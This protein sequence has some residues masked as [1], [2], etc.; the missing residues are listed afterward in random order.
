MWLQAHQ[1]SPFPAWPGQPQ[2][3]QLLHDIHP[4][5]PRSN[6]KTWPLAGTFRGVCRKA[7]YRSQPCR[8]DTPSSNR[9][10]PA[11][12]EFSSSRH[13]CFEPALDI[14][15]HRAD[16]VFPVIDPGDRQDPSH[17]ITDKH[18]VCLGQHVQHQAALFTALPESTQ[19]GARMTP[20]IPQRSS[21]G[22]SKRPD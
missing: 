9:M 10:Q 5:A 19:N 14:P 4:V 2:L 12:T 8:T 17:R 18:F 3:R 11:A 13:C 1:Q 7:L 6:L 15:G 21:R 22:V 20:R 16:V